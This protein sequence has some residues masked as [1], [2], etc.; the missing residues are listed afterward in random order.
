MPAAPPRD[1]E[2][3][4]AEAPRVVPPAAEPVRTAPARPRPA[5]PPVV[6]SPR[7][8]VEPPKPADEPS[9]PPST[10]QTTPA[11]AEGE[12]ERGIRATLARATSDLNRV[13]VRGLNVDAR[14]QYNTAKRFVTQAEDAMRAK[15]LVFA[16][17]VA[18][19]AAALAAQLSGK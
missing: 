15:N 11:T 13:D 7:P 9:R 3:P 6:E 8:V 17:S 5:P 4:A 14:T 19:K 10:L 18:D 16:R 1:I 12:V 2:P